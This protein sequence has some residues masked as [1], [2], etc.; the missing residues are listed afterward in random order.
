[1]NLEQLISFDR[2]IREGSFSRAAWALHSPQPTI[3]ARIKAL[4]Q[5]VGGPLFKRNN[6]T[7][8]LTER[9]NR[10]LPHARQ[11]LEA[12]QRGVDLAS[13]PEFE[14][15]GTLHIGILRS[16][17]GHFLSP[18]LPRFMRSY[19]SVE[20]KIR[21]SNHWQLVE[22]LHDG[23]IELG[24]ITWPPLGPQLAD[25]RPMLKFREEMVLLAHRSHP[26]AQKE[27]VTRQDVERLS[28]PFLL[29]TFW[30]VTPEPVKQLAENAT[31]TA[32]VPTDTGRFLIANGIGAGFFNK[33]QISPEIIPD[34]VVEIKIKD[35]GRLYRESALVR[36][37]R[38]S[39][40]STSAIY[41]IEVIKEQARKLQF[42]VDPVLMDNNQWATNNRQ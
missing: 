37:T 10:F 27:T 40:L 11:A 21:E 16:L 41:F 18:L 5:A 15:E 34:E 12:L 3:S 32:E 38:H 2:I 20:L 31:S 9:G 4:E 17:T 6:R 30:Q 36:L 39:T 25:M 33:G 13:Q 19:P 22:W 42:L 29:L 28:N 24:I 26:L 8:E 14:A 23:Q 35:L 7:V 1:M